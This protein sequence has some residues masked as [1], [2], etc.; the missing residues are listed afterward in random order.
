MFE[1]PILFFQDNLI[2]N[3]D[4][5]C[6]AVF[7]VTGYDY[8][9]LSD[10]AKIQV[11]DSLTLFL[12]NIVSEAKI[13]IIP[14]NQ[15]IKDNFE[16]LRKNLNKQNSL[17]DVA[18]Y[19]IK[20]I[21]EYLND[22]A[23]I[24]GNKN[25][26]ETYICIK[27]IKENESEIVNKFYDA[28]KFFV[29]AIVNDI[30]SLMNIDTK[31]ILKSKIDDFKKLSTD[32][33]MAQKKRLSLEIVDT[34]T[35]QWLLR[36]MSY[37]GLNEPKL[38]YKNK[39]EDWLPDSELVTLSG[40]DYI[41]PK[42]LFNLFSGSIY[43]ENHYLRIE[44][45]TATSYQTFLSITNIPEE[46]F[47]P[48]NEWIYM[49]QQD[50]A[51]VEVCIHV[52]SIEHRESLKQLD[53]KIRAIDSQMEHID[54]ANAEIPEDLQESK[55]LSTLLTSEL[56]G[57]RFPL[58]KT[59]ISICIADD[60]HENM[61]QKAN[62]IKEIYEDMNFAVE[63]PLADQF[64]L[65]IQSIP[66]VSFVVNDFI[67]KL[68]PY[69]LA[70]GLIGASRELGDKTG[71]YI[72]HTGT[73]QKNVFLNMALACLSNKSASTTFY[74]N[75]G[76]GKSFNANLLVYIHLIMYDAY[77]LIFD[78]KGERSHWLTE[79]KALK[80]K[81][82]LVTLS[83]EKKYKGM[84]DPFNIFKNDSEEASELAINI[85]S[86]LFK[87]RPKDLEYTAL[88]AALDIMKNDVNITPS[89]SRIAEILGSFP[90]DDELKEKA[91]LLSRQIKL[92]KTSGMS[93]LLV[94]NGTE[95]TINIDNRLN[96]LQI[97]NLK[98]PSPDTAK[99][100]Y[101]REENLSNILMMVLTSFAKKF[102][103]SFPG[104]F[105]I[106]LIDESWMLSKTTAGVN[107]MDYFSRMGRSLFASLVLNGHS[108]LDLPSEAI[109][110]TITY[111]FCFRTDNLAEIERMLKYL[112]LEITKENIAMIRNL[113]NAQ[114]LF[115]DLNRRVGIL[116]FDAVFQDLIDVFSTTPEQVKENKNNENENQFQ[117]IN[118]NEIEDIKNFTDIQAIDIYSLEETI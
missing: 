35:I 116:K 14:V 7:K 79:L 102:I 21:E 1:C 55:E 9:Y 47:F 30:N 26:Y 16:I 64:D 111:K 68:T 31:D 106:A 93:S 115:Q 41:R 17:Y 100:D 118:K 27:L 75:L 99:D 12:S 101:T 80:N 98:L 71:A 42:Q 69:T 103:H 86:E 24:S 60:N 50:N 20:D 72:G 48:G 108:V 38:F 5:S 114:C 104:H 23:A 58:L 109:K 11:L 91:N 67:L 81:I 85:L 36:R 18:I 59:S 53:Y 51:Q 89:M 92:L 43:C 37:R 28:Y 77:A 6:W 63:R 73:E 66:S 8:D 76:V 32:F 2:F 52:Q 83:S 113:G 96:I 70:S 112:N 74:G 10:E 94:G 46:S 110:N 34:R 95:E 19:Q 39:N 84:L 3:R 78:P 62:E 13:L 56:K 105:K 22:K 61:T 29:G 97:Q 117:K 40:K 90:I 88:L 82:N 45:E 65:F 15:S 33:F 107:L 49:L 57:S 54:E 44:H 25:D 87:L 4:K